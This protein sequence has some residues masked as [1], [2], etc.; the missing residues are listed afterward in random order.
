MGVESLKQFFFSRSYYFPLIV[1]SLVFHPQYNSHDEPSRDLGFRVRALEQQLREA[2]DRYG[3]LSDQYNALFQAVRTL[4]AAHNLPFSVFNNPIYSSS[5]SSNSSSS[6]SSSSSISSISRPYSREQSTSSCME[7]NYLIK[8]VSTD[9]ASIS[10]NDANSIMRAM[11]PVP[12]PVSGDD[13]SAPYH[14]LDGAP[15]RKMV[16]TDASTDFTTSSAE[17]SEQEQE[18][19][20][21]N[22]VENT[23]VSTVSSESC[24]TCLVQEQEQTPTKAKLSPTKRKHSWKALAKV[25]GGLG[26]LHA[27]T[28]AAFMLEEHETETT[29][30]TE[31]EKSSIP[32]CPKSPRTTS[33]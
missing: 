25:D 14:H 16:T 33:S 28:T 18:E 9:V 8:M 3:N 20:R 27:I 15:L 5:D 17:S 26:G 19:E 12:V 7:G 11:V 29:E 21:D 1:L 32:P 22:D 13:I 31:S 6:G 10:C 2:N 24:D 30:T 4:Y 23:V